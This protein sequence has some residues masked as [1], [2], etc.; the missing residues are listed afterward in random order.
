[1][2]N[3]KYNYVF[4]N[5]CEDYFAP[6]FADLLNYPF[7]K[8]FSRAF[9]SNSFIQKLFFLHWSAKLNG[10][11]DLPFKRIWFKRICCHKFD[12]DKPVC[13]VFLGGKYI[14]QN[15]ELFKYIKK[16]NPENKC[17]VLYLDL[18]SKG[19]TDVNQ[20]KQVSDMIVTYD[21]GDA[22]LFGINYVDIDYYTPIIPVTTPQE[23]ENDIYF[24]GYAKDR[25]DEIHKAYKYFSD[26][27]F[28]C[29]FIVC[30]TN[31]EDRISGQGLKY[32]NPVS[33]LENLENVRKSKCILEIIQGNSIAPTLRLRE[34]KTYK[35]KLITNNN[36]PEYLKS[37]SRDN[38]CIYDN[39]EDIDMDFVESDINYEVFDGEHSSSIKLINYLEEML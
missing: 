6:I 5:I 14:S 39:V 34:A 8:I 38:L 30:G 35:R 27:N 18:I 10:I 28:R 22:E 20:V 25:L 11:V 7:V 16:L 17:V 29:N 4:Y 15:A 31:P 19:G 9:N 21:R 36:N 1:M 26:N 2:E 37:L 13:Y 32:Q 33:Y 12:N 24:L 23:F 3:H